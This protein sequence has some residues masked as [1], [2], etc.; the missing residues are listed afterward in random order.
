L[1]EEANKQNLR[2]S[3]SGILPLK[4]GGIDG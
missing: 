3:I 4:E 1:K 2:N